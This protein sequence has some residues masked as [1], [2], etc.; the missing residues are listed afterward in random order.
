[1]HKTSQSQA[2]LQ[3]EKNVEFA[4]SVHFWIAKRKE[5]QEHHPHGG[6]QSRHGGI[7]EVCTRVG[8]ISGY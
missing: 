5:I 8:S 1:M 7:D 4:V 2:L 3:D 6:V